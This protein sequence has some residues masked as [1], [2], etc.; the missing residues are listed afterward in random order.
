[1]LRSF[2]ID[3]QLSASEKS[4]TIYPDNN[5]NKMINWPPVNFSGNMGSNQ[6]PTS[7]PSSV[8]TGG[9]KKMRKK[10][11]NLTKIKNINILYN[12]NKIMTPQKDI[13]FVKKQLMSL[14][15]VSF[16]HLSRTKT[17][18]NKTRKS[19]AVNKSIRRYKKSYKK[20]KSMKMRGGTTT[21]G[22]TTPASSLSPSELALANPVHFKRVL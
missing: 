5:G 7:E 2:N 8:F 20:R 15:S 14:A 18:Y 13:R 16:P 10:Q 19:K 3:N 22:Y 21:V 6:I 4:Y 1:M 9:T 11:Y 12:K 17:K